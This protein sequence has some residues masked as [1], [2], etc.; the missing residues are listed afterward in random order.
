MYEL[1]SVHDGYGVFNTKER[2]LHSRRKIETA[3]GLCQN[4]RYA[5]IRKKLDE[6]KEKRNRKKKVIHYYPW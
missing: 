1:V 2:F 4:L 3:K 6:L 5:Y